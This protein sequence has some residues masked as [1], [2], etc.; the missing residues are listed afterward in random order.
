M[1]LQHLGGGGHGPPLDPPL[2][3]KSK[4][5]DVA[6]VCGAV[7]AGLQMLLMM[8]FVASC[9][10]LH[11]ILATVLTELY[12]VSAMFTLGPIA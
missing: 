6:V 11:S 4:S 5:L 10:H 12:D 3:V 9:R 2:D 8:N 7:L 1:R